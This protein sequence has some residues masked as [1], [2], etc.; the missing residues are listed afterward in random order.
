MQKKTKSGK[1]VADPFAYH[2]EIELRI[3][4][5]TNLGAGLG[6]HAGNWVVMVAGALPGELVRARIFRNHA[7][8]SDG[9]LVKV[10]ETS[11]DRVEPR[12]PL[13]GQCGGCQYQNLSYP[14]QLAWKR[15][16]VAELLDKMAG[17]QFPVD[18]VAGSPLQYGYRSKITPHFQKPK[19]GPAF[20]I[21]FLRQGRRQEVLDV[22]QCPIATDSINQK[23]TE[24]RREVQAK[25]RFYKKGATLLL[26]DTLG[27]RVCTD[28]TETCE[29]KVGDLTFSFP[30]GEFFQNNPFILPDFVEHVRSEASAGGA[31]EY[32]VDCYCGSGLFC[33]SCAGSFREAAGIEVSEASI[34]WA[35]RN[36]EANGIKNCRFF[37][38][39]AENIFAQV[40]YPAAK[41][42][43]VIDPPR[44]GSSPE[45]LSQLLLYHPTRIVYVSCDP[46]TQ[47]RD[48]A[49]LK[50]HYRITRIKPF[51]LFPQT[52][53]LECVVTLEAADSSD[54]R[55][56]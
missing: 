33:L 17:I 2:E 1:F 16:Q 12:C 24:V 28:P 4:T 50:D 55:D 47:I 13:F 34:D 9:D 25:A 46:A 43:V 40:P 7:N 23:L 48:L 6:R 31:M 56:S 5:L 49:F 3:D 38:G 39:S 30:A 19:N 18:E 54:S 8:Y 26:R 41:S 11:P 20:P 36:A 32:L 44:K 27:G 52:R 22:P 42:A 21:G 14:A 53:H 51:D 45:F 10:L 15:R 29:E 35:R 37:A